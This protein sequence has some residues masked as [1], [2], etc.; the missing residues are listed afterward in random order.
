MNC[1]Y[2]NRECHN[3]N[4]LSHHQLR[5]PQNPNR[6]SY[7][8]LLKN[9]AIKKGDT[10]YTN[11][12]LDKQAQTLKQRYAEGS[13]ISYS[14]GKPGTFLNHHHSENTKK[15]IGYAVSKSRKAAYAKGTLKP[16][17][18]VGRGKYSYIKYRNKTIMLR[19]TY[20]FIYALY[21]AYEGI[22]FEV[23]AIRAPALNSNKYANTF[24]SDFSFGNTVVEIKGI[25]SGKDKYIRQAFECAGYNFVIYYHD[26]IQQ[27]K[28]ILENAG[29]EMDKLLEL[30]R[31]GH[32]SKNYFIYDMN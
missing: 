27:F 9:K 11:P 31:I 14:K 10:K 3:Q 6:R 5:C 12:V 15:Q 20:E 7:D 21:L 1:K 23:E 32:D 8:N 28:Q 17:R 19:S 2:C 29:Y 16:A 30:I 24:L 26:D 13:L 22:E 4:S 25:P 18:G